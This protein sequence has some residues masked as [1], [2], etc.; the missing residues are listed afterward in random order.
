MDPV[1]SGFIWNFWCH[2]QSKIYDET[3]IIKNSARTF[4]KNIASQ[5]HY[6][7]KQICDAII[8][9]DG[10]N[11]TAQD[12]YNQILLI[13]V[14]RK[15]D[16]RRGACHLEKS[17]NKSPENWILCIAESI[18]TEFEKMILFSS[19]HTSYDELHS[20]FKNN[21]ITYN[22]Y[23]ELITLQDIYAETLLLKRKSHF[24]LDDSLRMKVSALLERVNNSTTTFSAHSF[25]FRH[26]YKMSKATLQYLLNEIPESFHLL[27]EVYADWKKY[28]FY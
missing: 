25:W 16:G 7:Q 18:K 15:R 9:Y 27:K 6:L 8:H 3:A 1:D 13:R 28:K 23:A 10:R 22:E 2:C 11:K 20:I 24:D 12:I 19:F 17:G 5:K 14:Y 4:Q 21:I 26:Y